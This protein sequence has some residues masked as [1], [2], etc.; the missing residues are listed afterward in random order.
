MVDVFSS[1]SIRLFSAC[2]LNRSLRNEQ[3]CLHVI[4]CV[5]DSIDRNV[6]IEIVTGGC[7]RDHSSVLIMTRVRRRRLIS[8]RNCCSG[9]KLGQVTLARS[10]FSDI[11]VRCVRRDDNVVIHSGCFQ[12]VSFI[13]TEVAVVKRLSWYYQQWPGVNIADMHVTIIS[14]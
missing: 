10:M 12:W 11:Y 3:I 6:S 13:I 7:S 2:H 5:C 14:K 4:M 9:K 1:T 8:Q